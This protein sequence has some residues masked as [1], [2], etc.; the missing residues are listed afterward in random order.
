MSWLKVGDESDTN[1]RLMDLAT[2]EGFDERTI[3]EIHGFVCR[4]AAYSAKHLTDY[5]VDLGVIF[6]YG[7]SRAKIL[8]EQCLAVGLFEWEG[9]GEK[10]KIRIVQ[11]EDYINIRS[12]EDVEWGRQRRND[13]ADPNLRG[14]VMLRDGDN[15]RWCGK[16]VYWPGKP[17]NR[18]GTLDHLEPGS[19]GSVDT[20]VVACMGCNSQ[21]QDDPTGS[22]GTYHEL[23]AAPASPRYG[24]WSRKYLEERGLL[25]P[26][27]APSESPAQNIQI[28]SSDTP[29]VGVLAGELSQ[30]VGGVDSTAPSESPA[31]N[32]QIPSSDTPSVGVLAGE[33]S[34]GVGG[35]DSSVSGTPG[36]VDPR[37]TDHCLQEP[38]SDVVPGGVR[39]SSS[40]DHSPT[41]GGRLAP[42]S[43]SAAL[44]I[45]KYTGRVGKGRVGSGRE[46]PGSG[47]DPGRAS[48][49]SGGGPGFG[50]AG[51]EFPAAS[52]RN[53]KRKKK[54]RKRCSW[55]G[56]VLPCRSCCSEGLGDYGS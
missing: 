36:E 50:R 40:R 21:R 5:I 20:M 24:K 42:D 48:P 41:T 56:N 55:H 54:P 12:K 23:L 43:P 46:R 47:P 33:L 6:M 19:A 13:N 49:V 45:S 4:C 35:V 18:K 1:P 29:S 32:I 7:G 44:R 26:S 15:C 37:A 8:L 28:P 9:D 39:P 51:P 17:S 2:V 52:R 38:L 10:K 25:R 27:T 14:P 53:R 11:D 3:N 22:W 30:G 34:Q 31:Q 16:E